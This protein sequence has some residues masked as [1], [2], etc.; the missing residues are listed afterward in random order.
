[1]SR[2]AVANVVQT[3]VGAALLFAIYHY[4][5]TNLGVEQLGV[6]SVV[7]ATVA[8]S[9]LADLGL[10]GGVT[11][12]VSRDLAR[13]NAERASEVLDT[14]SLTLMALIGLLLPILY[15][16]GAK[17][18]PY[19]FE[20]VYLGQALEILPYALFGLWWMMVAAVFHGGLDGCQRMDLRAGLVIAGQVLLL[21]LAIVL[22]PTYGLLGLAWA[23]V[24]QGVF[25]AVVGRLLVWRT[26][27]GLPLLPRRWSWSV[28][29]EVLGYGA[30]LQLATIFILLFD[31]FTK[32]LMAHFGGPAA[33]GYFEMASRTV[34][35]IRALIVSANQAIVPHVAALM[36]TEAPGLEKLY[37]YNMDLL[38][39]FTLPLFS[40]LFAWAG[41]ISWLLIGQY[42]FEFVF[43][44][45]VLGLAWM[46]N[47]FTV[48][49]YF[50]N[51]GSG[52][53]GWN[54]ISHGITGVVNAGLGLVLGH[55]YGASGVLLAYAVALVV[56]SG[57]LYLVFT[58][59]N[60]IS[61]PVLFKREHV[62]LSLG[63]VCVVS[64]GYMVPVK[65][66]EGLAYR[67]IGVLLGAPLLLSL[68]TWFHPS[69]RDILRSIMCRGRRLDVGSH[70]MTG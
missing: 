35:K 30:N 27:P 13:L 4:I 53:I 44:V 49:A 41:V 63:C 28:L 9:H 68:A 20:G 22:V 8:V 48:P 25:L 14:V 43:M 67:D 55:Y 29:K 70:P 23:Q 17:I 6:W 24:V 26:L 56:G 7:L 21:C 59:M 58:S 69:G 19:L 46:G 65:P 42:S 10:T 39:L 38:V 15:T 47:I 18:L 62:W 66:E 61:G 37:R 12:F 45:A 60:E 5:N 40:I 64:L 52:R 2:N 31:A 36:E 54:T 32:M 50:I 1:M 51:M 57:L 33:A 11:R 34:T 3:I 16:L